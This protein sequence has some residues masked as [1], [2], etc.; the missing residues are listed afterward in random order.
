MSRAA[1]ELQQAEKKAVFAGALAAKTVFIAEAASKGIMPTSRIA[2]GRW[3]V[4]FDVVGTRNP[5]TLV[6]FRGPFH[7][8]NNPT[9]PH[10]ITPRQRRRRRGGPQKRAL[11]GPGL[12]PVAAVTHPGT[13]G[14]RVFESALPKVEVV[15]EK[16]VRKANAD[17]LRSVFRR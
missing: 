8:V 3:G 6:K 16:A 2:G 11:A 1:N 10:E 17:A 15:V 7:L 4:G 12:G 5:A 13:R 9:K 14:K